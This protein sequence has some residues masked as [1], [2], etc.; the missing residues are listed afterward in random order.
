MNST[1]SSA[2]KCVRL[3]LET[4]ELHTIHD[5]IFIVEGLHGTYT[6]I[7]PF[8]QSRSTHA[9]VG[10]SKLPFSGLTCIIN[11]S[12][13]WSILLFTLNLERPCPPHARKNSECHRPYLHVTRLCFTEAA[14]RKSPKFCS[15]WVVIS[16]I[17]WALWGLSSDKR[18]GRRVAEVL[19][20]A[21]K[22]HYSQWPTGSVSNDKQLFIYLRYPLLKH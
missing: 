17:S 1:Y 12:F 3:S 4:N 14:A 20:A 8:Y 7:T 21:M 10:S 15:K 2:L 16:I 19:S 18:E 11:A 22:Q 6:S 13:C 5:N 9:F